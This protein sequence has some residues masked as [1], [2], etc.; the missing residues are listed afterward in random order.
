MHEQ[1]QHR[2]NNGDHNRVRRFDRSA[3]AAVEVRSKSTVSHAFSH[4]DLFV[5]N[6]AYDLHV[7]L[8]TC[9]GKQETFAGIR[10]QGFK[11]T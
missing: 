10:S 3:R 8:N 2:K 6:A 7:S 5:E 4:P 11:S 9:S 1:C